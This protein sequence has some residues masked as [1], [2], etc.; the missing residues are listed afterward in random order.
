MEKIIEE[1]V[2]LAKQLSS[3]EHL[4]NDNS[5][6]ILELQDKIERMNKELDTW[7]AV[8]RI[9]VWFLGI[10]GTVLSAILIKKSGF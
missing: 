2:Q 4:L 3:I 1:K 10:F 9:S 8:R 5:R 6:A 7:K